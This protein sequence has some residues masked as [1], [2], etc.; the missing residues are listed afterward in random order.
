[1]PRRL[2]GTANV[3]SKGKLFTECRNSQLLEHCTEN[4]HV[5]LKSSGDARQTMSFGI[6]PLKEQ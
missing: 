2:V 5:V 6:T 3:W 1:M 4:N